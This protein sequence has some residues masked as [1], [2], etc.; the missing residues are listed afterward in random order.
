MP[1]FIIYFS[2]AALFGFWSSSL[3]IMYR[4]H[5]SLTSFGFSQRK[6]RKIYMCI[7][8]NLI[9][10]PQVSSLAYGSLINAFQSDKLKLYNYFNDD[11]HIL[12]IL[13][14]FHPN[15]YQKM[16]YSSFTGR[17]QHSTRTKYYCCNTR[18][19]ISGAPVQQTFIFF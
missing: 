16:S 19:Y 18:F 12:Y 1:R 2:H 8:I 13:L 4:N 9:I 5:I 3:I 6:C 7:R 10:V 11:Q 14:Y 17:E 15:V